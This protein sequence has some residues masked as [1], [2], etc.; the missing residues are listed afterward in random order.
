MYKRI[1]ENSYWYEVR[2]PGA[3]SFP[4]NKVPKGVQAKFLRKPMH[5]NLHKITTTVLGEN[6]FP[7]IVGDHV[8][9]CK[10]K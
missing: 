8:Y 2:Q 9:V 6:Q 4:F 7:G 10:N 5:T 3:W 1:S